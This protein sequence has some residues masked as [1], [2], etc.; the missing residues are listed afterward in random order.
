[1]KELYYIAYGSNINIEQMAR[2]C[3]TAKAV[4][5]GILQNYQLTFRTFA[6]IEAIQGTKTPVGIWRVQL[7]DVK[8]LDRYEGFPQQYRKEKATVITENGKEINAMVYIMNKGKPAL[9][10]AYYLATIVQGYKDFGLNADAIHQ[11]IKYTTNQIIN[12]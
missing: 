1:M 6:T 2:R 12:I 7:T 10:S 9:P 5:K 3:P 11:A 8:A 4:C